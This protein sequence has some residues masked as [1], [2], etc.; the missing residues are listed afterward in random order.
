MYLEDL[1]KKYDALDVDGQK[2]YNKEHL[3]NPY[4]DSTIYFGDG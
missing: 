4:H 2:Y 1:K 3:E